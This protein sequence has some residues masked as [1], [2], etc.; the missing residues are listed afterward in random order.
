MK[1]LVKTKSFCY[2]CNRQN[3]IMK[4]M[5]I[6]VLRYMFHFH[7]KG[8]TPSGIFEELEF[9][10]LTKNLLRPLYQAFIQNTAV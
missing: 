1:D 10:K 6:G 9:F 2:R 4:L 8:V 7:F 3:E 5:R